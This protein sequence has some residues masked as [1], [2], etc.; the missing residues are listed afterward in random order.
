MGWGVSHSLTLSVSHFIESNEK[1]T[2]SLLYFLRARVTPC[3][4]LEI[5]QGG[6]QAGPPTQ[7]HRPLPEGG[8]TRS[9]G[10]TVEPFKHRVRISQASRR[11]LTGK[12]RERGKSKPVM[13]SI[14][15]R[16]TVQYRTVQYSTVQRSTVLYS[17]VQYSTVQYSAVHYSAVQYST[18][19][20]STEHS[21]CPFAWPHST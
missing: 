18:V 1:L 14:Q 16:C 12:G 10:F 15:M 4:A 21:P 2:F 11:I 13:V 3:R 6:P 7:L 9:H 19:Q 8:R 17:I 20:C 5:Y